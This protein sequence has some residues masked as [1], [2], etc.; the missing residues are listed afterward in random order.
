MT[1]GL[2]SG[3]ISMFRKISFLFPMNRTS[4]C[5]FFNNNFV[6]FFAVPTLEEFSS[7]VIKEHMTEEEI[8]KL[9]IPGKIL[10]K[11]QSY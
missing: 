10:E 8:K 4:V 3:L 2:S 7:A 6:I 5:L 1:P 9:D 11:L